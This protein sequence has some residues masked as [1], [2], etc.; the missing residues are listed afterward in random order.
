MGL[1]IFIA[2]LLPA[3]N[4]PVP[5]LDEADTRHK[6]QHGVV[7]GKGEEPKEEDLQGGDE[8]KAVKA[9][10]LDVSHFFLGLK[11]GQVLGSPVG[12]GLHEHITQYRHPR[13][14]FLHDSAQFISFWF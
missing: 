6:S 5:A 12:D 7:A 9:D 2:A 1:I 11:Y 3:I 14:K 10:V 8:G 13:L 4:E